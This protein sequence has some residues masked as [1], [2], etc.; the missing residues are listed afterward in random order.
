MNFLKLKKYLEEKK[1]PNFRYKQIT[2]ALCQKNIIDYN[3]IKNIPKAL[4]EDLGKNISIMSF[5]AKTVQAALNKKSY[6]A[7]LVLLD[8]KKIETVLMSTIRDKW[9]ICL[10]SQ[11]GCK[12]G[13]KFCATGQNGFCRDLT[14]E[15]ITDQILFWKNYIQKNNLPGRFSNVVFMGM[16]EPFSNWENVKK[17]IEILT[18]PELYNL[19]NRGISISTAGVVPGIKALANTFPQI[20]L[21]ISLIFPDNEQRK[22]YMPITN[23]Y[24]LEDIK[25]VLKYYLEKT[26][27][28]VFFEY[29]LLKNL[30]DDKISA[31]KLI[32]FI[33]D[34]NED[35]KLVQVNLIKYNE[36]KDKEFMA[37]NDEK[38]KSFQNYLM[39]N[40]IKVTLRKSLG[41]D[42]KGACGQLAGK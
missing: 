35:L 19:R 23:K 7:L 5:S 13:C 17:S 38:I 14:F 18:S 15:E 29:V 3:E 26:N 2:E 42:I 10:S 34:L 6:K 22:K 11:V 41:T 32:S 37:P 1:E 39:R 40:R 33:K 21:A 24:N 12:M 28:K 9:T 36:T 27:R 20:N 31:E 16:G 4:S 30:N 25:N 8:G